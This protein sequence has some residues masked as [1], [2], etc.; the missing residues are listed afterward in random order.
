MFMECRN[1]MR[2]QNEVFVILTASPA[3]KDM[4]QL[5]W[6]VTYGGRD[7][8]SGMFANTHLISKDSKSCLF[9]FGASFFFLH[10]S[11]QW[12]F[13]CG[14]E[15]PNRLRQ[16][17]CIFYLSDLV[18]FLVR[19]TDT[20]VS[21]VYLHFFPTVVNIFIIFFQIYVRGGSTECQTR[22]AVANKR[23]HTANIALHR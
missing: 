8:D 4:P 13:V 1:S 20:S 2:I 14:R 6:D 10:S 18:I 12:T 17:V 21:V 9:L 5:A 3:L 7:S 22:P 19:Y 15:R 16:H 23:Q 11:E